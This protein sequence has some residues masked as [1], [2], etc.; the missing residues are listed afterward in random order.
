MARCVAED[1]R[2]INIEPPAGT[3]FLARRSLYL[4]I[5]LLCLSASAIVRAERLPVRVF[6]SA[7]G[8]GSSFVNHLMRDSRGFLWFATRDGLSRFD[9]SRFVT[10]QVGTT[11]GPP[12]IENI[13]ETSR[14][15][16]WIST[17]GGLFRYDPNSTPIAPDTGSEKRPILN[18]EFVIDRRGSF[19]EDKSG[20]LWFWSGPELSVLEYGAGGVLF[21][22]IDLNRHGNST[23]NFG[24]TDVTQAKDGSLWIVTTQGFIRRLPD[25]RS[26]F[27]SHEATASDLFSS[28]LEDAAG[29][30]WLARTSGVYV[31]KPEALET[32]SE[33]R[34]SGVRNLDV[35]TKL[36]TGSH[37][38]MPE[39]S[40]EV[41]KFASTYGFSGTATKFLYKS[42]DDHIWISVG[43]GVTEFDGRVFRAYAARRGLDG[44]GRIVEDLDGNLWLGGDQNLARLDRSGFT[45]FDTADGIL[46]PG[47]LT[48]GESGDG[49]VYVVTNDFYISEFDGKRFRSVRPQLPSDARA[50][51][52]SNAA[53]LDS[54]NEWWFLT[55]RHLYRYAS[56]SRQKPVGVYD[57]ANGLRSGQMYRAFEDKDCGVWFSTR[58]TGNV[59][60][61]KFTL[62]KFDSITQ[63]FRTF[64]DAEDYPPRKSASAFAEDVTGNLWIGFYEGGLV[65]YS[66]G[67][68][69]DVSKDLP[70]GMV[71][72][73]HFDRNGRL[74]IATAANGVIRVDDLRTEPLSFVSYTT[75]NALSSNNARSIT[76]DSLG[77]IYIGTARGIDRISSDS[78]HIKHYSTADGL[79]GDFVSVGYQ[80]RGG[81]LWFGTPNGLS[82]LVPE[83]EI[84]QDAPRVWLSGLKIGGANRPVSE[85]GV[86]EIADLELSPD[87]NNLQID[88]FGLDF[89]PNYSLRYQYV[90]EGADKEWSSPTEQRTVNFSSLAAGDYRFMVRAVNA[91]GSTS[92]VPARISF[93]LLPPIW[94]RWWFL[95]LASLLIVGAV[96][97]LDRF[98]VRKTRQVKAALQQTSASETRYR[99]LA[100][101][102]SD[103]II[104][105]DETSTIVYVNQAAEQ[106]FGYSAAEIIGEPLTM[107]M[108]E[109]FRSRHDAGLGGF[110]STGTKNIAWTAVEL[111]GQHKSGAEIPLELSFGEFE[112]DGKRFFTGIAR[113]ISERKRSEAALQHAREERLR[114]LER[115]RKRIATDL[116]DDVGSSLTQIALFSEVARQRQTEKTRSA[117]EPLEFL[118]NISNELVETMSD[119]VWAIN[120]NK[121]QLHDLT[122]RMRHFASEILTAAGIDLEFAAP[123]VDLNATLGANLRREIFLIFKESVNNIVKHSACKSVTITFSIAKDVLSLSISD[124]GRGFDQKRA[125]QAYDWQTSKGGNGLASMKR[126]AEEL[127]GNLRIESRA[128]AGTTLRLTVP[129]EKNIADG[130][131][132]LTLLGG[133]GG[134]P[135][136]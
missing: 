121:D 13:F 9:G 116:H 26:I 135:T 120:P 71:T 65:R 84:K 31:L 61:S 46:T 95:S 7:D 18:A 110:I 29:R 108:P 21:R 88:F 79:A 76:E 20:T 89:N 92:E 27:F 12:G 35:L 3:S 36:Q 53:I 11:D 105:I 107:L 122:Q 125:D 4:L 28:V 44:S 59:D 93:K 109:R 57:D 83:R 51:W 104:T 50:M 131:E 32:L 17:T 126:R 40:G 58:A 111:P 30:I 45:T 90:L 100:Q 134:R 117:D 10:Y 67:R 74:W 101:T 113:D 42:A 23:V 69:T 66:A 106:I 118:V 14:G 86:D 49:A 123:D 99:T 55:N 87:Q 112:A 8:L 130:N 85:L 81:A 34:H 38:Q 98:R 124:D 19:F 133:D 15:I 68:F 70:G 33:P 129:L 132:S 128:L 5:S 2:S 56:L 75:G 73:L 64:S 114:E 80:D 82:R 6:T 1:R 94:Q 25:G 47:I 52:H 115:V 72:A 96:V 63:T 102:A 91:E 77:Q 39:G 41:F 37:P 127:G 136:E 24:I 119:I 103:A 22:P 43:D 54:R 48:I 16:Y 60:D 97:S 78:S 62:A